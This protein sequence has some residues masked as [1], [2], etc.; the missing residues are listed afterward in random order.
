[1]TQVREQYMA[2][3]LKGYFRHSQNAHGFEMDMAPALPGSEGGESEWGAKPPRGQEAISGPKWGRFSKSPHISP[4][5]MGGFGFH[6]EKFPRSHLKLEMLTKATAPPV[7]T[8]H[9][10]SEPKGGRNLHTATLARDVCD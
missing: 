7:Q 1:M 6:S 10:A 9:N 3:F 8:I 2:L 5:I 4:N